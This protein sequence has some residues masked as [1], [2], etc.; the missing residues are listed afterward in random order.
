MEP[1]T[2]WFLDSFLLRHD[3]NSPEGVFCLFVFC[4]SDLFPGIWNSWVRDQIQGT[5][6]TYTTAAAMSDP[7][8]QCAKP[9][10]EPASWGCRDSTHPVVP[11]WELWEG[12]KM[13]SRSSW[14]GSVVTNPTSIH[15]DMGLILGLARWVRDP[16]LL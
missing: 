1:E 4:G 12:L 2:S 9:R 16:A 8:T 10:I 14:Y 3:G 6:A 11:Q 15:E 5:I 13:C 7:L